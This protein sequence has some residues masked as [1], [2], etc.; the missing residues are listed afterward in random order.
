[1]YQILANLVL[2]AH[3]GFVLFAVLGGLLARR[4]RGWLFL[5]LP[6]LAWAA[7]LEL[8]GLECPL[9]GLENALRARAA[10]S[11]YQG[12]CLEHYLLAVL[13]PGGLSRPMQIGL[14][15]A[16]I[17]INLAAYRRR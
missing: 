7:A 14:G 17:V 9:S 2:I 4:H 15:L 12:G 11:T 5:H 13:Y 16:V 6:A 3:L 8:L 10:L 1:M